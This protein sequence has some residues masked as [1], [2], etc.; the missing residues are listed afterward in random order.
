MTC[1]IHLRNGLSALALALGFVGGLWA[2]SNP[3]VVTTPQVRAELMVWA[4]Q[5]L[6]PALPRL[7]PFMRQAP[8][9][10]LAMCLALLGAGAVVEMAY[11]WRLISTLGPVTPYLG[12][13]LDAQ[14]P[15]HWLGALSAT[16]LGWAAWS[17]G[18]GR[19]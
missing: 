16:V 4:P 10:A 7:W 18:R 17:L 8:H 15:W 6:G 9:R 5:G 19:A 1:F 12:L 2:Q 14:S 11:Q 13:A 3:A